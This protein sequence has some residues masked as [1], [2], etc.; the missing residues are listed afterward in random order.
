MED[1][2][3]DGK[4]LFEATTFAYEAHAVIAHRLVTARFHH[5]PLTRQLKDEMEAFRKQ[6]LLDLERSGIPQ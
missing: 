4:C 5:A 3:V 1:R 2:H 6:T